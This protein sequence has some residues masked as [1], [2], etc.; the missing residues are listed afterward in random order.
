VLK[1]VV[2]DRGVN[3]V[4]SINDEN[5]KHSEFSKNLGRALA[6][7]N[8]L[9]KRFMN[10]RLR[11]F[12]LSGPLYMFLITLDKKPGA[13]QDYLVEK[14][15]MDKGNVAR[16]AKR[17][18]DLGYILR[19]TDPADKRQNNLYLTEKGRELLPTIYSLLMEWSKIM[20]GNFSDSERDTAIELL[21]RMLG[22]SFK[23]FS[24]V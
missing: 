21:E 18:A 14:F 9:R 2:Y 10:E 16:G 15:Y 20:T 1:Y 17:L 4:V 22:N 12:G 13:S 3:P 6:Q 23:Y 8:R 11:E 19:R 5:L 24:R 7:L